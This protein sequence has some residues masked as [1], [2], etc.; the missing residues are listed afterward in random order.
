[1]WQVA[2]WP[3]CSNNHFI[4]AE[5]SERC[6]CV[7]YNLYRI[8]LDNV[9]FF[10]KKNHIFLGMCFILYANGMPLLPWCSLFNLFEIILKDPV[11]LDESGDK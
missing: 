1:L 6:L 7:C 5:L 2:L 4:R 11:S 9:S 10:N 3:F 8:C